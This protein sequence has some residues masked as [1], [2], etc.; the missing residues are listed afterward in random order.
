[1]LLRVPDCGFWGRSIEI[2]ARKRYADTYGRRGQGRDSGAGYFFIYTLSHYVYNF[3]HNVIKYCQRNA[4]LS[5]KNM[6]NLLTKKKKN[7]RI[8][9][10]NKNCGNG[11][12]VE[13]HLAKVDVAGSIPVFRSSLKRFGAF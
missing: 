13:R 2:V 5:Y 3:V 1:M 7:C 6:K 4:Y 11:S 9:S 12:M 10:V 8:T